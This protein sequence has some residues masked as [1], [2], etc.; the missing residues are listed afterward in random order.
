MPRANATTLLFAARWSRTTNSVPRKLTLMDPRKTAESALPGRSA[1]VRRCESGTVWNTKF[2]S[3]FVSHEHLRRRAVAVGVTLQPRAREEL[4][5]HVL[6]LSQRCGSRFGVNSHRSSQAFQGTTGASFTHTGSFG[7]ILSFAGD[8]S[9]ARPA[10]PVP[11]GGSL[12]PRPPLW[13]PGDDQW[14][15]GT[16]GARE[17]CASVTSYRDSTDLLSSARLEAKPTEVRSCHSK[18]VNIDLNSSDPGHSRAPRSLQHVGSGLGRAVFDSSEALSVI[19]DHAR[20][21]VAEDCARRHRVHRATGSRCGA[22]PT[23]P[24]C[25]QTMRRST[26]MPAR[27]PARRQVRTRMAPRGLEAL[28][29]ASARP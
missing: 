29:E 17:R 24:G 15:P 19:R 28:P 3:M 26:P 11:S 13:S 21:R 7:Y 2:P 20:K 6:P 5:K 9:P 10:D 16:A 4:C 12:V 8:F 14:L 1:I 27:P 23:A 25:F 18:S 22:V